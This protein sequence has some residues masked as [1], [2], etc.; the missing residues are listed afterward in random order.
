[1][2]FFVAWWLCVRKN[3]AMRSASGSWWRA[4]CQISHKDTKPRRERNGTTTNYANWIFSSRPCGHLMKNYCLS[5]SYQKTV[6]LK[7]S[8][9]I[10]W[11]GNFWVKCPHGLGI[12]VWLAWFVVKTIPEHTGTQN[13][14]TK[15]IDAFIATG[16]K[17]LLWAMFPL[18]T[19]GA[20]VVL[21]C[22]MFWNWVRAHLRV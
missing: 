8:F 9:I 21:M 18:N 22:K 7:K 17:P 16:A 14:E 13:P 2:F 19:R 5:T 1:M 6:V 10:R 4:P 20:F 12:F 3:A 11:L 15:F